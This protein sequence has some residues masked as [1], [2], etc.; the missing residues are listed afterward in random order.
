[1]KNEQINFSEKIHRNENSVEKNQIN[2]IVLLLEA[3]PFIKVSITKL[4]VDKN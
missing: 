4:Y 2:S 1:M 3:E